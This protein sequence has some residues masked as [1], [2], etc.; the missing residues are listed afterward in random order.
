MAPW[1]AMA[2]WR[3][4]AIRH[5]VCFFCFGSTYYIIIVSS[6]HSCDGQGVECRVALGFLEATDI[7]LYI[8]LHHVCNEAKR[9][10]TNQ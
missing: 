2:P 5:H 6:A 9:T 7:R 10:I 1:R 4:M 3:V 8:M